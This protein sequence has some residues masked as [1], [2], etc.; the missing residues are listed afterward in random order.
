MG[1]SRRNVNTLPGP[2]FD[3]PCAFNLTIAEHLPAGFPHPGVQ[4]DQRPIFGV[5]SHLMT[6]PV[7]DN[8]DAKVIFMLTAWYFAKIYAAGLMPLWSRLTT[9]SDRCCTSRN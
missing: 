3:R 7:T 4:R 8:T 2:Q 6:G 1:D 5:L 9:A